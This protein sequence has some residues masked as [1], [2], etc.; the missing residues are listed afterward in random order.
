M[1]RY[2]SDLKCNGSLLVSMK[3]PLVSEFAKYVF[4]IHKVRPTF[5]QNF[6]A[7]VLWPATISARASHSSVDR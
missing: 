2:G 4:Q 1:S 5:M 7:Y 3:I 6:P